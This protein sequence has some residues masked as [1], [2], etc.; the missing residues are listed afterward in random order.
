[1][2]SATLRER[3]GK[4]GWVSSESYMNKE[5][6]ESSITHQSQLFI[7]FIRL[8]D[9]CGVKIVLNS[10]KLIENVHISIAQKVIKFM[11]GISLNLR[12]PVGKSIG[13]I[14]QRCRCEA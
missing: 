11:N 13:Q 14:I 3:L 6:F 2:P 9:C 7:I 5:K 1:M 10:E 12:D 8:E 4:L